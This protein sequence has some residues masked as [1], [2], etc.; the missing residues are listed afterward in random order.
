MASAPVDITPKEANPYANYGSPVSAAEFVG[1]TDHIR[2]IRSRTFDSLEAA[3]VSIVGPPRV[4]KSSLAKYV[5]DQFAV[6][7]NARGLTFM[8]IWITV[9]GFDSEQALFR[10]LAHLAQVWLADQ[11]LQ[12]DQLRVRYDAVASSVTWDEMRMHLK[13]YLRQLRRSGF[14]AIVVLDEFDAARNIF[15]RS[16]P[17]EFLRAIAYEPELR[18]ALITASRRPLPDI[19]VKSTAELSTFPQIFGLPVTLGCFDDRELG[20]LIERSPYA[21]EQLRPAL[22]A[23]LARETGGQPFLASTLLSVLH[24][25]WAVSGAPQLGV[26]PRQFGDAVAACGQLIVDHHESMLELLREAGRFTKLLEVLFG[27]QETVTLQDA[28]QMAREGIITETDT[29]WAAFSE[30]FQQYLLL[31]D[32]RTPD[33]QRLWQRTEPRLRA[34][35]AAAL[36]D[37]YGKV[38]PVKLRESQGKLVR[39]CESRWEH[40]RRAYPELAAPDETLLDYAYPKQLLEIIMLHWEQV[41]PTLGHTRE[42]WRERLELVAKVRTP[43]AHNRRTP[44]VLMEQFRRYC[45]EILDWLSATAQDRRL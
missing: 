10:E 8:P 23:L 7:Q 32:T 12:V 26:L 25:R 29:G 34:A 37:A 38:W 41:A 36:E 35:L 20:V 16:A 39:D 21:D 44:P 14:Q 30:S 22:F 33:D 4:G 15:S 18:V 24:E 17:F 6:G 43:M 9:S 13:T 11:G 1:R 40:A 45:Q 5:L 27:P 3:S 42:G 2:G 28:Q 19:V 31:D